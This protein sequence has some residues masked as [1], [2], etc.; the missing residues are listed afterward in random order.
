MGK[1]FPLIYKFDN[2]KPMGS[3]IHN[4]AQNLLKKEELT[5][6][7]TFENDA[8]DSLAAL[9]EKIVDEMQQKLS[10]EDDDQIFRLVLPDFNLFV[11]Q[12]VSDSQV[13][14]RSENQL[15]R[16]LRNLKALVRAS[17][18]ICLISVDPELL[19]QR[20]QNNLDNLADIVLKLTSFKEHSELKI[21]DYDGTI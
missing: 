13:Q 9:W 15:I 14:G 10:S 7:I 3:T 11:P 20:I 4:S 16:F 1:N 17:N 8:S 2:S 19:S 18:L 12:L 5:S 6:F 21:G